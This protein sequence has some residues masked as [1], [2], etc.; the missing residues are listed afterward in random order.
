MV[1]FMVNERENKAGSG[2]ELQHAPTIELLVNGRSTM[3]KLVRKKIFS[4]GR[5]AGNDMVV[6]YMSVSRN[7]AQI[8]KIGNDYYIL[9]L[10]SLYGT[11][12]NG[13]KI[14]KGV[15]KDKDRIRLGNQQDIALVFHAFPIKATDQQMQDTVSQVLPFSKL[16]FQKL[17]LLLEVLQTSQL[18]L[19][20]KVILDDV[21]RSVM[22]LTNADRGYVLLKDDRGVLAIKV[23]QFRTEEMKLNTGD[24]SWGVVNEVF[25]SG[26]PR[27]V[28]DIQTDQELKKHDSIVSM[29]L[30]SIMCIPLRRTYISEESELDLQQTTVMKK[31]TNGVIYVDSQLSNK[32]FTTEDVKI[33]QALAGYASSAISNTRLYQQEKEKSKQLAQVYIDTIR[34]LANAIEARD[35]YTRGHT[36]R[37][38]AMGV[39][40]GQELGWSTDQIFQLKMGAYLHDIG[41]IGVPDSILNKTSTLDEEEYAIMKKHPQIGAKIIQGVNSLEAVEPYLLYHQ[42]RYD[43]TGYPSALIGDDIPIEGRLLAV[44]DVFDALTSKRPYRGPISPD[45]ALQMIESEKGKHF[46]PL[47]VD[48][49]LACYHNGKIPEVLKNLQNSLDTGQHPIDDDFNGHPTVL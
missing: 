19:N 16:T 43:G 20:L 26:K 25:E 5:I 46:D 23:S 8:K 17:N 41:K 31:E 49:F 32:I 9:D 18:T 37:V 33:V 42:E 39:V 22:K 44:V 38:A 29:K 1:V 6:D 27:V 12:L 24:L 21:V 45:E 10:E 34:V 3:M 15:L 48:V 40:I 13:R 4:I 7:H 2:K 36:E 35:I 28:G 30:Q 11:F 14:E 47:I